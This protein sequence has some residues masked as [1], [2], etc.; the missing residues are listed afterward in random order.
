MSDKTLTVK[1]KIIATVTYGVAFEYEDWDSYDV[2]DQEQFAENA[3]IDG[4][5]LTTY[6]YIQLV[7]DVCDKP[8]IHKK[9]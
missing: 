6:V 1:K 7:Q 5:V 8:L 9:P 4:N 2:S 3:V